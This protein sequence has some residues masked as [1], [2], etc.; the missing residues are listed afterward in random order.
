[1]DWMLENCDQVNDQTYEKWRKAMKPITDDWKPAGPRIN[2]QCNT[3]GRDGLHWGKFEGG[4][5]LFEVD[6]TLHKC[7][8][9]TFVA[10]PKPSHNEFIID[11]QDSGFSVEQAE[12]LWL[13]LSGK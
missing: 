4:Y 7:N 6:E 1:M 8:K 10:E 13:K 9:A 2:K 11:A 3:C 5:R 12:F